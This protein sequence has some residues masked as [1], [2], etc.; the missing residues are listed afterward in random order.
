MDVKLLLTVFSTI[1]IAELGDKTQIATLLYASESMN[2]KLLVF[3]GSACALVTASGIAVL[4][5]SFLA[6]YIN[7][8]YLSWVAGLGFICVGIW[9]IMKA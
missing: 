5:G 3:L 9:T 1:F 6:Q 2:N 7:S 8:K 4:V